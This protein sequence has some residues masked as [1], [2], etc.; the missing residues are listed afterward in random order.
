[1]TSNL[2]DVRSTELAS[3]GGQAAL[4]EDA[5]QLLALTDAQLRHLA[6]AVG[7]DAESGL[8]QMRRR[9][10][11]LA[12]A[13]W[14]RFEGKPYE[15]YVAALARYV[16]V[17]PRTVKSWRDSV[18]EKDTL[19]VPPATDQRKREA[20]EREESRRSE[21]VRAGKQHGISA[22]IPTTS[23]EA[24]A[25][26]SE[27]GETDEDAPRVSR[28]KPPSD[29]S[30]GGGRDTAP[31]APTGAPHAPLP[32][33]LDVP[34]RPP[35]YRALLARILGSM[36]D[37]DPEDGGPVLTAEEATFLQGWSSRTVKAWQASIGVTERRP[38]RVIKPSDREAKA[39]AIGG[40][41]DPA[42]CKHPKQSRQV[43]GYMVKCGLCNTKVA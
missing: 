16:G 25:Q 30:S 28:T 10:G 6:A 17:N 36:H 39:D 33:P 11:L 37:L 14:L 26:K 2:P 19:A 38:G 24:P 21:P 7:E 8:A 9:F 13:G 15:E 29:P 5:D 43:L 22:P 4:F 31:P 42:T 41:A 1:M 12:W 23:T 32:A 34:E 18:V 27:D 40:K 35:T 3:L 20:T